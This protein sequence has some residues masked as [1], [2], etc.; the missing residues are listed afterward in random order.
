MPA[1]SKKEGKLIYHLTALENLPSIIERGL[2]PR[3]KLA[4][5]DFSDIANSDIIDK[6]HLQNLDNYIPFHFHPRTPFDYKVKFNNPN[7]D[8]IYLCIS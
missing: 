8:F 6:R 5:K 4:R 2:L 1:V 3:S 7:K